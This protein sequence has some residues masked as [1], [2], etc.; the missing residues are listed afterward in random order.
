MRRIFA[1]AV[2]IMTASCANLPNT[3]KVNAFGESASATTTVVRASIT[4][5]QGIAGRIGEEREANN[6]LAGRAYTLNETSDTTLAAPVLSVRIAAV[7]ALQQYASALAVASDRKTVADLENASVQLGVAMSSAAAIAFPQAAPIIGPAATV[8]SRVVGIGLGNAYGGEILAVIRARDKDVDTLSNMLAADMKVIA[9]HLEIQQF[10]YT[11]Y[12]RL[13]L[14][15]IAADRRVDRLSLYAEFKRART[16][17]A[18]IE[19]LAATAQ[20]APGILK[21]MAAAHHAL[22]VGA[23]NSEESLRQFLALADDLSELVSAIL[24]YRSE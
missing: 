3:A 11:E 18:E 15:R 6:L 4:A 13:V 1:V 10:K 21:K 22:A 24:K 8:I 9:D 17:V 12:R 19:A 20:R 16:D 5:H 23:P 7:G 2:A 14:D